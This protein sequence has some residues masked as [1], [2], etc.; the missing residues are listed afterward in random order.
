MHRGRSVLGG[1]EFGYVEK[2]ESS[3]D[4]RLI[5]AQTLCSS[6]IAIG[7]R[8]QGWVSLWIVVTFRAEAGNVGKVHICFVCIC[9]GEAPYGGRHYCGK[10]LFQAM[11][12]QAILATVL[13]TIGVPK[14][15]AGAMPDSA[16]STQHAIGSQ[17]LMGWY[18]YCYAR[19]RGRGMAPG[20]AQTADEM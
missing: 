19:I 7:I 1:Q 15:A 2:E 3:T 18:C 6:S 8:R 14:A 17:G 9:A 11:V 10:H 4:S 20:T 5:A 12:L 16:R 13:Q